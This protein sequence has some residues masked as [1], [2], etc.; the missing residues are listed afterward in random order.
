[1]HYKLLLAAVLYT[2][3]FAINADIFELELEID[4]VAL[5]ILNK[6]LFKDVKFMMF[7]LSQKKIMMFI[8]I[9]SVSVIHN[10]RSYNEVADGLGKLGADFGLGSMAGTVI[11]MM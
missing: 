8:E 4:A 10:V 3:Q 2:L 7:I 6:V 9:V 11:Q 5:K 1:M